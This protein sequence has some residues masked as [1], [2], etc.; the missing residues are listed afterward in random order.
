MEQVLTKTGPQVSSRPRRRM[1]W[2]ALL[3]LVV[4]AGA[5][6]LTPVWMIMPFKAQT[7]RG[8]EISYLMRRWSP[9]LTLVALA[10]AF[11]LTI[12]L[13]GGAWWRKGLLVLALLFT[14]ANAWA[15]RQ[16]HFEWMF[17]P[18]PL[19]AYAKAAEADFVE[20]RDM[21]LGVEVNG[22]A[23][24]YPVR[25]MAYHHLVQDRVGGTEIVATY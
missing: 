9:A 18:L 5:V 17:R 23:V 6:V 7:A 11:A 12:W 15:A 13:W 4:L 20:S 16:N 19:G 22:E 14:G 8:M 1:A 25:Q 24:A 21:V 2:L 10:G 3:V